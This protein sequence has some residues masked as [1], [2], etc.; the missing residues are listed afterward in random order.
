MPH[1]GPF[2][3][4]SWDFD[5]EVQFL[6]S[7]GY[8]VLQPNFRGSTGYGRAFVERGYGQ[9]GSGM[10]DDMEDGVDWL[11]EQGIVDRA[12]SASW[13][14]PMAAMRRCG[15]AIRSPHRY[16]CAISLAGSD[17]RRRDA[18]LR[19]A[20]RRRPALFARMAAARAG[21]GADRSRRHLAAPSR[22]AR[23]HGAAADRPW[24]ARRAPCRSISRATWSAR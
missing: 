13:A 16:R 8:A 20:A 19:R 24:R 22:P 2:M 21:R 12:G 7:R 4:D 9:F 14:L 1:G 18:P 3:R 6:A 10:I 23:L 5:P 11:V 17:R 15:R